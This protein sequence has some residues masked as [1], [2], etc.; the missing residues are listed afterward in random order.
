LHRQQEQHH[1]LR[2]VRRRRRHC[3]PN[4]NLLLSLHTLVLRS[5]SGCGS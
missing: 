2:H 1:H 4:Q 5:K 3:R